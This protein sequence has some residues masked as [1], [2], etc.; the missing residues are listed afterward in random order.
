MNAP[1][2]NKPDP[3]SLASERRDRLVAVSWGYYRHPTA[4]HEPQM[5]QAVKN[6]AV[7]ILGRFVEHRL[8][9]AAL[10]T[11]PVGAVGWLHDGL[12]AI[13]TP[14]PSAALPV[15]LD[16]LGEAMTL[17]ARVAWFDD[18]ELIWRQLFPEPGVFRCVP[19]ID[20][21][22]IDRFTG[23]RGPSGFASPAP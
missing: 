3:A 5:E 7:Q 14:T 8:H 22:R 6:L 9:V 4:A 10:S 16:T 18:R 21:A 1:G 17:M 13:R 23:G 12:L 20:E 19:P 11:T 15:I 2:I